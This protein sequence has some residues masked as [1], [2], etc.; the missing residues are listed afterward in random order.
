MKK[1]LALLSGALL[2]TTSFAQQAAVPPATPQY[3]PAYHFTPTAHWMNDPN[4]M[5]YYQGTYHLFFQ[6]YPQGMVWGPMHWGH[7]TSPD[8]VRWQEQPIAL[9]P[10]SLGYIF[11]GSAVVD[12]DN[13]AGFGKNALVAIFTHHSP[14]E[15]KKGQN[16]HQYQSLAYS[17]DAGK[18]WTKYAGNPVLPNPG[19]V[20]FRDPKVSWNEPAKQW[21]MTL[22]TK[23]R[24]T[25]YSSPNLKEWTKL[26]E[27]GEKLGAHGG[28]W[29]CP[30]LF[31]LMLNGKTYWVLIVNLNPGGPN[32][33]S[34]TQYFVGQFDGKTFTPLNANTKW[35]DYGPDEYAGVTW[36][37]TGNRRLFLGWMSNWEY[38]NQVPTSPWR[39]ATTIPRELGLRQ[40]GSE[41][42]LTSQ[43]VSELRTLAGKATTLQNITVKAPTDLTARLNSTTDK[44]R[45]TLS[46]KQLND[47]ELVL[48]NVA[49]EEL[50]VGYDKAAKQ[51]FID[52]SKAGKNN[53]SPKFT[54]RATAPRL[55]TAAGTEL[56]LYLDAASVELFADQGLTVMTSIFFASKPLTSIKLRSAQGSTWQ[57]LSNTPLVAKPASKAPT[58]GQR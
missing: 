10:D 36:N 48:G 17:L 32:G 51:Y 24:I 55:S 18:T 9:A 40:V 14:E 53:F 35:A 49:G 52:R 6:Y 16:K 1:L 2:T 38:A 25:F 26:S 42:Y 28:V 33:G 50:I 4:G 15:E 31:P 22:A 7:A 3:R 45:L 23:D 19:I 41:I 8:M 30:D 56:T 47:F 54:G 29:E 13:T 46:T 21:V 37:N 11:S 39:S 27:F 43:P 57:Q 20:D 34:A 58:L 44:H 5:V 12:A